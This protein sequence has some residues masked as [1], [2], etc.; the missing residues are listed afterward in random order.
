MWVC[1]GRCTLCVGLCGF[2]LFAFGWPKLLVVIRMQVATLEHVI[3]TLSP[4]L[5]ALR[6]ALVTIS[7][8]NMLLPGQVSG[9]Q[10]AGPC[11]NRPFMLPLA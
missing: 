10:A 8:P 6:Q 1:T 4:K 3:G 7:L 5:L 2:M 11:P 9:R